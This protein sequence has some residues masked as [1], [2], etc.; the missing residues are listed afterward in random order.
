[1][2]KTARENR[3]YSSRA[4]Q[5][6]RLSVLVKARYKCYVAEKLGE[7]SVASSVHHIEYISEAWEKRLDIDNLIPI[8]AHYH[9]LIHKLNINS[10]EKLEKFIEDLKREKE[11]GEYKILSEL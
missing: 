4:W 2:D 3:F 9:K 10:K 1:S 7:L 11:T 8:S 5:T 6:V